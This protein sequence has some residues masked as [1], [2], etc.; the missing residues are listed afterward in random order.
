MIHSVSINAP[1]RTRAELR[2]ELGPA[3]AELGPKS[4]EL[5]P[6]SARAGPDWR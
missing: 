4:A 5:G 6:S 2:P 1:L 3:R